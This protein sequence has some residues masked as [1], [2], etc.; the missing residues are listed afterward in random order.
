MK[1]S[2]NVGGFVIYQLLTHHLL[3]LGWIYSVLYL[4]VD[5]DRTPCH[6]HNQ[7]CHPDIVRGK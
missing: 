7:H 2:Q 3:L 4:A 1:Y 5:E 6:C